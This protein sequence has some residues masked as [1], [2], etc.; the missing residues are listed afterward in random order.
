MT[1]VLFTNDWHIAAKDPASRLD[2]YNAEI[3]SCLDQTLRAAL[4]LKASAIC[5]SGDFFHDK[6]AKLPYAA[7]VALIQW[8]AACR[9][10]NIRVIGI[11]GNHDEQDDRYESLPSQPLGIFFESGLLLNCSNS[12]VWANEKTLGVYGVPWPDAAKP[13]A[14][15]DVP[16][17]AAIV[18]GHAYATIDGQ[19]QYGQHCHKYEDLARIAPHVRIWHF[20]H[21]H[22][23]HGVT[24]LSNG[25]YVINIGALSRGSLDADNLARQV[26]VAY[27]QFDET[28]VKVFQVALKVP[29]ADQ[30]FDVKLRTQKRLEKQ[31]VATFIAQLTRPEALFGMDGSDY[32]TVLRDMPM[33]DAIRARVEGYIAKAEETV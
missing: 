20:G 10:N 15:R 24:K 4:L 12:L 1:T 8:F 31:Q 19:P 9:R 6:K 26:K 32:Q 2:D 13:E 16:G 29:P 3:F 5:V 23:D 30:V 17:S 33:E 21:D 25:A 28:G 7:L 22:T 11:P 18:L 14:F 27:A